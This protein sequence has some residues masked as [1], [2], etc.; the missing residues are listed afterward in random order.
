MAFDEGLAERIRDALREEQGID[1]KRMFGGLCLMLGG[2][3]MVGIV[4]ESLMVRVGEAAQARAL[5]KPGAR[6]MDFTG[7]P[8]KGYVFVDPEGIAEDRNL[9]SWIG[10][11]KSY[12]EGLAGKQM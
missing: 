1:E 7:R 10:M 6:P 9:E 3:M 11:A 12:V 8:M 4:K 2:H 5:A